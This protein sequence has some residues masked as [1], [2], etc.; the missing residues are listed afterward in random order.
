MERPVIEIAVVMEREAK[1]NRWQDWRHRMAEVVADEPGFGDA[2][3]LLHDDG[4]IARSLFPGFRVELYVDECEGYYLNLTSGAPVWF[5]MWRIDD[6]DA[7]RAW[8][9]AVSLSYN[10]AGRWLDAQERVDNVPLQTDLVPWLQAYTDEH[11]RPEVKKA[12]R[13]PQ[14]FVTPSERK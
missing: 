10:E 8:P 3:R 6:E 2:P 5:V 7:S 12:R 11:Y 1:P 14:S 4:R 9:E 13:R